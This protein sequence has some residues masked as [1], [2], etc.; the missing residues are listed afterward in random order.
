MPKQNVVKQ[1][2]GVT[3]PFAWEVLLLGPWL[4][5]YVSSL[6]E[7][8]YAHSDKYALLALPAWCPDTLY[9]SALTYKVP[10]HMRV[11]KRL[12]KP[13][14]LHNG[15]IFGASFLALRIIII[16]NGTPAQKGNTSFQIC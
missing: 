5:N 8:A 16:I 6:E 3:D 12:Q 9:V 10:A 4:A 7:N 1:R 15:W 2:K 11:Q 14:S 13:G